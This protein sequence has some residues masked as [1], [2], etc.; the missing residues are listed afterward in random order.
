MAERHEFLNLSDGDENEDTNDNN[1]TQGNLSMTMAAIRQRNSRDA[2]RKLKKSYYDQIIDLDNHLQYVKD[3]IEERKQRVDAYK[4][5]VQVAQAHIKA[6]RRL[7]K[8][9]KMTTEGREEVILFL[10]NWV[11]TQVPQKG[12][13][14]PMEITLLPDESGRRSGGFYMTNRAY[15]L[16]KEYYPYRLLNDGVED[17]FKVE[18]YLG[19]DENGTCIFAIECHLQ[20]NV[21]ANFENVAKTWWFDLVEST[22]LIRSTIEERFAKHIVYVRQE[23][24]QLKYN[25]LCVAGVFL[26]HDQDRITITQTGIALDERFPFQEGESRTNGYHWVVFQHV[27][28][29]LTVVRWSLVTYCPVNANG[30]LSIRQVAENLRCTVHDMDSKETL[31]SKIKDASQR[32]LENFRDLFRKRCDRFKLEQ[33]NLGSRNFS[34]EPRGSE[35]LS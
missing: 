21:F 10:F 8:E 12:R 23:Y 34:F 5:A 18:I 14:S 7:N 32:T 13:P 15:T 22:D 3:K 4:L 1:Q 30:P 17:E 33:S 6:S 27:E 19:E 9:L 11:M 35:Q 20:F 24:P 16:S 31:L 2:K 29:R 26:D 28:D 25:R